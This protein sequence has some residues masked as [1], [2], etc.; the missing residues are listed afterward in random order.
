MSIYLSC[1]L[2]VF[3]FLRRFFQDLSALRE[4]ILMIHDS[5][6]RCLDNVLSRCLGAASRPNL[7]AI[8]MKSKLDSY[9]NEELRSSQDGRNLLRLIIFFLCFVAL[10]FA[11]DRFIELCT[12]VPH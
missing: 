1:S 11:H 6:S 2:S 10:S 3:S 9:S 7:A 8:Q 4:D 12:G 5:L